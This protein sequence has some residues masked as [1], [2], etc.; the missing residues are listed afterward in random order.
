[1]NDIKIVPSDEAEKEYVDQKLVEFNAQKV[2][3]TQSIS[4]VLIDY[5]LKT[6][7]DEIIGGI[8]AILYHWHI[9]FIDILWIDENYRHKQYGSILLKKAEEKAKSLG[10]SL[11]HLDTFDF[12]AQDFYLKNGYKIFGIL[13]DCPPGHKRIYLK[14]KLI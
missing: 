5:S 13:E 4:P 10:C 7:K 12:Q 11:I 1:M 2:P 8:Q 6:D 9:L 3:F 14:K